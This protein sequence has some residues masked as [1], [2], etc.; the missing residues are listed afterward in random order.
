MTNQVEQ[1]SNSDMEP[2]T[3]ESPVEMPELLAAAAQRNSANIELLFTATS[4]ALCSD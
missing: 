1:S 3:K 4:E 2:G